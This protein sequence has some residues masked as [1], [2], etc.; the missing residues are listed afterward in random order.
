[1]TVWRPGFW[2]YLARAHP[3]VGLIF[4]RKE[5]ELS[6]LR[7]IWAEHPSPKKPGCRPKDLRLWPVASGKSGKWPDMAPV[8]VA[9]ET[10]K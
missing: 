3:P 1:M 2:A 4:I 7:V 8:C 6:T 9:C 5:R 10:V